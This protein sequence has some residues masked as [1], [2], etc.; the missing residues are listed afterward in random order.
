MSVNTKSVQGRRKLSFESLDEAVADAERLVASP[1]VTMLG[2]LSLGQILA[3]LAIPINGAIDGFDIKGPW[4]IRTLLGPRIKSSI[5]NKGMSPGAKL[6]KKFH[7]ELFPRRVSA[8][9]GL[10]MYRKAVARLKTERMTAD[11]PFMGPM[12]HEDW[13]RLSRRHAEL[14]LSFAVP[15]E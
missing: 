14:H 2:N 12:C 9:Q 6:P 13:D 3:H 4:I 10:E 15:H 5:L 11:H 8:E 1:R 7:A